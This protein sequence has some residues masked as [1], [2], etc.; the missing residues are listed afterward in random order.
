MKKHLILLLL[1]IS[2]LCFSQVK[3][4]MEALKLN[5]PDIAIKIGQDSK[6]N[7]DSFEINFLF[8]KAY[9]QKKD[10]KNAELFIE[11]AK[12][13]SN[14]NWQKAWTL[15][16]SIQTYYGLG[17]IS[18]AK[19]AYEKAKT[20]P[21]TKNSDNELKYWGIL[22]GFDE[23]YKDWKTVE[24][25]NLIFH[26]ENTISEENINSIVSSRQDAFDK[27]NSFFKSQLPK[28]IDFFVWDLP[29]NYNSHL[30]KNLG[31]TN[32]EFCIS[33]NRTN[34]SAGHEIAHSIT[35]WRNPNSLKVRFI[36]EGI[37]VHF[38]QNRNDKMTIA[39]EII[40]SYPVSIKK[41]WQDGKEI[42]ESLLYPIAGAFVGFLIKYDKDKFFQL[43]ENQTYENAKII[44]GNQL[45]DLIS[46]FTKEINSKK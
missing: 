15:V 29:G 22:F 27:I 4:M 7:S 2:T 8:A 45:A 9:N 6:N 23:L 40:L 36:N 28:K 33:H 14:E 10:F 16:E 17:K 21:G 39:N 43:A 37:A 46:N 44:Y 35:H 24:S 12:V 32:P 30:N 19:N 42:D 38:D 25:K 1:S 20:I 13:L 11:K 18:E 26:F 3:Q 5:Q 34:Q 41:M 31:F